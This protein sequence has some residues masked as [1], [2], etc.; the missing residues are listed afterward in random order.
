MPPGAPHLSFLCPYRIRVDDF[1][2]PRDASY[3]T[4]ALFLLSHTHSDHTTGLSAKS[5][6]SRIICSVDSKHMLL[7]YEPAAD[8][9]A[10]DNGIKSGKTRTFSHLSTDSLFVKAITRERLSRDLLVNNL[11][12]RPL[13]ADVD[14]QVLA[15]TS[16]EC[17]HRD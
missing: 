2:T 17:T 4:P 13:Y 1:T 3:E 15:N 6:G 8:R 7:N 10:F 14:H 12:L 9:I 11:P 5:F 16:A